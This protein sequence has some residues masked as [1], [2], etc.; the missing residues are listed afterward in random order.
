[1]LFRS[2]DGGL[3]GIYRD[4]TEF[5]EQQ[6]EAE[7]AR[8]RAE[9]AQT[10]LDDALGS[11][12]GGVGIWGPDERL[13]QCNAAY[14]AVNQNLPEIVTPGTTLVAAAN[15][16]MRAQYTLLGMPAPEDEVA[17]LAGLIVALHRKGEGALEF[18]AGPGAWTRLTAARTKS[19]GCVS[20]FSDITELRQ[21]QRDLRIERDAAQAARRDPHA[22]AVRD[23]HLH[24]PQAA[25]R[26]VRAFQGVHAPG[27]G[28]QPRQQALAAHAGPGVRGAQVGIRCSHAGSL[29]HPGGRAHPPDGHPAL[30][31]G[32]SH[33]FRLFR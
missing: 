13:I 4:I 7:R 26:E 22:V 11:M 1:M 15:A 24:V 20:L 10:L 2:P 17:R 9:A 28:F 27:Q 8:A 6:G 19:G 23:V 30:V 3:L 12:T 31:W 21:R 16:A 32:G 33:G 18:P 14:R 25:E 5:K 29:P